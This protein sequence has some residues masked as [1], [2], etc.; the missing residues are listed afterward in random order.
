[1]AVIR[2]YRL[3]HRLAS[4]PLLPLGCPVAV[5]DGG[6]GMSSA[7]RQRHALRVG[8]SDDD[9]PADAPFVERLRTGDIDAFAEIVRAWSPM[10][11]H[12]ARM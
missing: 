4:W 12:V 3:P 8:A 6:A 9:R 1:M 10:M 2:P 5:G 11:L 7:E